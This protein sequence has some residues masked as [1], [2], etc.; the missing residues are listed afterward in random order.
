MT[1]MHLMMYRCINAFTRICASK[2]AM[3]TYGKYGASHHHHVVDWLECRPGLGV[4]ANVDFPHDHLPLTPPTTFVARF[5]KKTARWKMLIRLAFGRI[6]DWS[7]VCSMPNRSLIVCSYL[8][9][10]SREREWESRA[11]CVYCVVYFCIDFDSQSRC[12]T[13]KYRLKYKYAAN[14]RP[15]NN[16]AAREA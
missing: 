13:K 15:T 3:R 10:Q 11:V 7:Q 9:H 16:N 12:V 1:Y 6:W 2:S 14:L 5:E 8:H 4:H